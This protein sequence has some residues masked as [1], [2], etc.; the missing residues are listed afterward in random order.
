MITQLRILSLFF[1]TFLVSTAQADILTVIVKDHEF[2]PPNLTINEGD[3][4]KW[5][6]TNDFHN[7]VAGTFPQQTGAFETDNLR[8]GQTFEVTFYRD[9]L[10]QFPV[11]GDSYDYF[12]A[13]HA[14][15][16][17][18]GN[19]HV[20]RQPQ[21]FTASLVGWQ[22]VPPTTSINTGSCSLTLD[23]T[24]SQ[25]SVSC[26]STASNVTGVSLVSAT[27][28]AE[29]DSIC[30]IGVSGTASCS[31][32][33]DIADLLFNGGLAILIKSSDYPNGELRGQ[34][35]KANGSASISG[36]VKV[37]SGLGIQ[38]VTV[39]DGVRTALT[40]LKGTFK[41]ESVPNGVYQLSGS[42]S[43]YQ[44]SA[45]LGTNPVL[46]N[47]SDSTVRNFTAVPD[48]VSYLDFDGDL[49][50]DPGVYASNGDII[51]SNSSSGAPTEYN[52]G[53]FARAVPGLYDADSKADV[54]VVRSRKGRIEWRSIGSVDGRI[55][56]QKFGKAGDTVVHGCRFNND[57]QSE[58]ALFREKTLIYKRSSDNE[59]RKV[60]FHRI[61]TGRLIGCG[62][63]NGD[64]IDELLFFVPKKGLNGSLLI[65]GLDR[66]LV[67]RISVRDFRGALVS[68]FDGDGI[69]DP[70]VVKSR[71]GNFQTVVAYTS[72][73][74]S[75][76]S[77]NLPAFRDVTI[78]QKRLSEI[79]FDGSIILL[80]QS[81]DLKV[82]SINTG[83]I[84]K[85]MLSIDNG[86]RVKLL[87][88]T[89]VGVVN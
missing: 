77:V 74:A 32:T 66:K 47:G 54:A 36:V 13:P 15:M 23:A 78:G 21:N 28:G 59:V 2:V 22:A 4:V 27:L 10:R 45:D 25:L 6:W 34:I 63:V 12:C 82:Y 24:E 73:Q 70:A 30:D 67:R 61:G 39:T 19:I 68:D 31:V 49:T 29:G 88:A 76:V 26:G 20:V 33:P 40:N 8:A 11:S 56:I 50:S 52:L 44:V 71:S 35:V 79:Q 7:V 64:R 86:K 62:D 55:S 37:K 89:S 69:G 41:I 58:R 65:Y 51:I 60:K 46:V 85:G 18:V 84:E 16:G 9:L 1:L 43:S 53:H 42:L 5:V 17:M 14:L 38:G 48:S 3:T 83:D 81:G 57:I 87:K 72:A 80:P 75:P